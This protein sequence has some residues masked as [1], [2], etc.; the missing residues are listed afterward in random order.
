MLPLS[1]LPKEKKNRVLDYSKCVYEYVDVGDYLDVDH[2]RLISDSIQ[3]K[4]CWTKKGIRNLKG[5]L[6]KQVNSKITPDLI[7]HLSKKIAFEKESLM[8]GIPDKSLKTNTLME[9]VCV[10]AIEGEPISATFEIISGPAATEFI[11]ITIPTDYY[12]VFAWKTGLQNKGKVPAFP[13]YLFGSIFTAKCGEYKGEGQ[14]QYNIFASEEQKCY[15]SKL[16]LKRNNSKCSKAPDCAFCYKGHK[17]CKIATHLE[18]WTKGTC[19]IHGTS[20]FS[21]KACVQCRVENFIEKSEFEIEEFLGD[22]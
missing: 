5:L 17:S 15:N 10:E 4:F 19:E 8:R 21:G 14:Y 20:F 22:T 12:P 18:D 11:A 16:R 13:S 1:L 2:V 6:L 7:W 3:V 9:V